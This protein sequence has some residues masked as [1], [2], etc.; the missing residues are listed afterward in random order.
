MQWSGQKSLRLLVNEITLNFVVYGV[1]DIGKLDIT[2]E[3]GLKAS[4]DFGH[5][6]DK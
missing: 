3:G 5:C 2:F 1:K 4:F 6:E